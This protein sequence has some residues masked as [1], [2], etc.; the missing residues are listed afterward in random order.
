MKTTTPETIDQYIAAFPPPIRKTLRQIRAAIRQAAPQASETIKYR[1]PT[2]TLRGNLVHFAAFE[3]H[4]GFYPAPSAIAAFRAELAPY[5]SA[6]GSVQFPHTQ[7]LPIPLIRKIVRY[8]VQE[9]LQKL[10]PKKQNNSPL[11]AP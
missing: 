7:S 11:T 6:K 9:T 8:R 5:K 4:L 2:F 10:P 3:N 1:I